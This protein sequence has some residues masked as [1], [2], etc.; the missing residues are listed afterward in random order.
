MK[1]G[2]MV[3]KPLNTKWVRF[4]LRLCAKEYVQIEG[5]DYQETFA[6]AVG[7]NSIRFVFSLRT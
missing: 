4:K 2:N 3:E 1:Y 6:S 7:Y 5:I